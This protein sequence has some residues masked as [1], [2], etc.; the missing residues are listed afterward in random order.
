MEIIIIV[1]LILLNGIFSMSE[2]ALISSRKFKLE[3]AAKRGNKNAKTALELANNPN[4]FLSTVQIGITLIGILTG[5]FSGKDITTRLELFFSGI[6]FLAPQAHSVSVFVIVITVTFFS[7]VF[8]ELIPKRIGLLYPEA[9]ASVVARP[10]NL[11]STVAKP[12]IWLLTATNDLFMRVFGMKENLEGRVSEEEI[13]AIV[14]HSAEGGEIQQIEHNIVERVFAL[15]DRKVTELM[16]HRTDIRW[17]DIDSS[18][19]DVMKMAKDELHS[20]YP[21]AKGSLDKLVGI[22]NV[23]ELF[24]ANIESDKFLLTDFLSNPLM[25]HDNAA[26]YHV[27]EKF[28]EARFHLAV[29][30]DE[31][32]AVL[33]II[34]MDDVLDALVGD[35]SEYDNAEYQITR[36]D[37]NS[38]L[39]DAQ[40]P[41]FE[42][43]RY[44]DM[45]EEDVEGDYNTIAG[46]ILDKLD[47]IPKT[48]DK[49]EWN[50]FEFEVID[51]DGLRIDKLMIKRL[52]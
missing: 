48:G 46:L 44:F 12:F 41:F 19:D 50:G 40:Y 23:K 14:Q 52:D 43:L 51:M 6:P 35:V 27:L 21:V 39:A 26:A 36:R 2:I 4:K 29:I 11:I 5:I 13:K 17:L 34:T 49:L 47:K 18:L 22:V 16:T 33:G 28:R 31:Y 20:I 45:N 38:W 24:A 7:I 8:G 32:G 9:I 10:M 42:L 3:H 1:F 30:V 25:V 37:D 15:G